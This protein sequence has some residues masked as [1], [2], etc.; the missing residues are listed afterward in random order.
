MTPLRVFVAID[1]KISI[2][3]D[4]LLKKSKKKKNKNPRKK[5]N[6]KQYYMNH[7]KKTFKI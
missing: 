4:F 2:F 3:F 6:L 7:I 5:R 1:L